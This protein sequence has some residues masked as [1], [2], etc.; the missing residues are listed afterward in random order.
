M[1]F[2]ISTH[3]HDLVVD[4]DTQ[5]PIISDDGKYILLNRI[6]DNTLQYCPIE[7]VQKVFGIPAVQFVSNEVPKMATSTVR[8]VPSKDILNQV[9][10]ASATKDGDRSRIS[11]SNNN[12]LKLFDTYKEHSS[13]FK[14]QTIRHEKIW[15]MISDKLPGF[16]TEQVK[17]KFKYLKARFIKKIENMSDKASGDDKSPAKTETEVEVLPAENPIPKAS[18]SS[19]PK[20]KKLGNHVEKMTEVLTQLRQDLNS[21]E[22]ERERRHAENLRQTEESTAAFKEYIQFM[23]EKENK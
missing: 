4:G 15:K 5:M 19:N 23:K 8:P 2:I 22:V 20:E 14:G 10:E 17:N 13:L 9:P 3:S 12:I 7:V 6:E 1:E 11:W 18:E 21:R 16:T